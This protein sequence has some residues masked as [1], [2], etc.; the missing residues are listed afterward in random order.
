MDNIIYVLYILK[1][2]KW[3]IESRY[4]NLQA[5]EWKVAQ[6]SDVYK[7][8]NMRIEKEEEKRS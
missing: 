8:E 4:R 6:Y 1:D 7:L 5:A 3:E 2:G